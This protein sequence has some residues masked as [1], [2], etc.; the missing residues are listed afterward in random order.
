MKQLVII[1]CG[2]RKQEYCCRAQQMY[3][4]DLYVKALAYAKSVALDPDIR[5]LSAK[6]G[7]L[8][9]DRMIC[10]YEKRITTADKR[11]K[12]HLVHIVR[13][14]LCDLDCEDRDVLMLAGN[15]YAEFLQMAWAEVFT[16]SLVMHRPLLGKG[17]GHQ[18]QWLKEHTKI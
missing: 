5:I 3:I 14:Q 6:Y 2:A 17:I 11:G 18:M 9:L 10:P 16:L 13:A 4:G 15:D 12:T 7:L 8:P 1:G